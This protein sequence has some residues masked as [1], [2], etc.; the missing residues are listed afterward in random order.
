MET[1]EATSLSQ[2]RKS[3]NLA[4]GTSKQVVRK[5]LQKT[6]QDEYSKAKKID[7]SL[8]GEQL[9]LREKIIDLNFILSNDEDLQGILHQERSDYYLSYLFMFFELNKITETLTELKTA[10][11]EDLIDINIETKE[12][13][14]KL[15]LR[16]MP[17]SNV[18]SATVATLNEQ[19]CFQSLLQRLKAGNFH[20]WVEEN[21]KSDSF[22]EV[23]IFVYSK[24]KRYKG[25]ILPFEITIT[26][27]SISFY[28][29]RCGSYEG[30]EIAR[31]KRAE[32]C[33]RIYENYQKSP[34]NVDVLFSQLCNNNVLSSKDIEFFTKGSWVEQDK[35]ISL[36]NR[37]GE[38]KIEFVDALNQTKNGLRVYN[39][40]LHFDVSAY[41]WSTTKFPTTEDYIIRGEV[42]LNPES[43]ALIGLG[44][45]IEAWGQSNLKS[46]TLLISLKELWVRRGCFA[47]TLFFD[48]KRKFPAREFFPFELRIQSKNVTISVNGEKLEKVFP[49]N[50]ETF[51]LGVLN[52]NPQP[53]CF[54]RSLEIE[55]ISKP[56]DAKVISNDE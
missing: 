14:S 50:F 53:P 40:V 30:D 5:F 35:Q 27:P 56:E 31:F 16:G 51:R 49:L 46:W 23:K 42:Y 37:P 41:S 22:S 54:L 21:K 17:L 43:G 6:L 18:A 11:P 12:A 34:K 32:E 39:G 28:Q 20:Y 36:I 33:I 55:K 2:I 3:Q 9:S 13:Y 7:I 45:N 19:N 48:N 26:R 25:A 24:L 29:Q 8:L 1:V 47:E 15:F 10:C 52:Y 4:M 44:P 38:D